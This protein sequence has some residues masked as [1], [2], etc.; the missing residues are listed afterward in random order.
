MITSEIILTTALL[1]GQLGRRPASGWR[2]CRYSMM[3]TDWVRLRPGGDIIEREV[4]RERE[5]VTVYLESWDLTH[6]VDGSVL[7]TVLFTSIA[8]HHQAIRLD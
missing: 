5:R 6:R 4:V 3:A 1:S 7:L 8:K 2:S